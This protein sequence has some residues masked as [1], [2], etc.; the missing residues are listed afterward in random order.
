MDPIIQAKR[1]AAQSVIAD[2]KPA[3]LKG[4]VRK[5]D[6]LKEIGECLDFARRSVGW[7]VDRLAR[8]LPPAPGS[9]TRDPRQVARWIRGED[10]TPLAVI[11][12]VQ[13]LRA[14]FTI[15]LAR[16]SGACEESTTLT[17]KRPA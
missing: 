11:F 9:G 2:L 1:L 16:L 15:A 12:A 4:Q 14:P 3:M 10:P 13:A 7:T 8:E 6:A 17:F 5:P